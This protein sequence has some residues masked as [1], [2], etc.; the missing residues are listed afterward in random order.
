MKPFPIYVDRAQG[1]RKWDVDGNELIDY[2]MGHGSLLLGHRH[3]TMIEAVAKQL[4]RSTHPGAC[5][6]L[7]VR[8]A[9]LVIEMVPCAERVRFTSSGTEAT[10]MA[11]RLARAFTGR[12]KV[13]K[14]EGH[15]HGWHS[16]LAVC[17]DPPFEQQ[18]PPGIPRGELDNLVILPPNDIEQVDEVLSAGD[19]AC[20]IL[21]PTGGSFGQGPLKPGFLAEL[22][23]VTRKHD[24]LLIFD[25]VITGFRCAPGGAQEHFGVTPDL[26]TL[27]KILV[28]GLPGAAVTGRAEIID[29]LSSSSHD[30]RRIS[31]AGTYNANPVSAA[32]GIATLEF[33]KG[34]KPIRKA[35]EAAERLRKGMADIVAKRG[36]DWVVFGDF[37][38]FHMAAGAAGADPS[39]LWEFNQEVVKK[40]AD[41]D[42]IHAFRCGMLVHG[43]DLSGLRGWVSS[44][45]TV[46]DVDRTLDAFGKTL[47]ILV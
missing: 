13:V 17:T 27:G 45:H 34:G 15:F 36:L 5:H 26:T 7:E 12:D 40:G 1:S 6:E 10:H 14:F 8:W 2:W 24:V 22:R 38:F 31:H 16:G 23:D 33:I 30:E 28:G 47:R 3:P 4:R 43:V 46:E 20:V 9:E 18:T 29:L 11:L 44:E 41:K 32:A 35:N 39:R 25:E 37:S 21:E 42:T 19:V